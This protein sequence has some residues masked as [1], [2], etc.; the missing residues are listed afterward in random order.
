[1]DDRA[2]QRSIRVAL[3][4]FLRSRAVAKSVEVARAGARG[5]AREG[6][7]STSHGALKKAAVPKGAAAFF[8]LDAVYGYKA[9]DVTV[10]VDSLNVDRNQSSI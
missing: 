9:A 8:I 7:I 4:R 5:A 3:F 10:A 2:C 1:M 6:K